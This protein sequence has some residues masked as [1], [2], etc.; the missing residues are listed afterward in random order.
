MKVG[1]VVSLKSGGPQMTVR[2]VR[3]CG[4]TECQWFD[5]QGCLQYAEFIAD[6]LAPRVDFVTLRERRSMNIDVCKKITD[7][8]EGSLVT[9]SK[10]EFAEIIRVANENES[11]LVWHDDHTLWLYKRRVTSE[12]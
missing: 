3:E 8:D 10:E 6:Q 7:A 2:R 9:L 1:D 12:K 4:V 11:M 5:R